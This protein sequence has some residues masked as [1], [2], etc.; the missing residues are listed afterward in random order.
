MN[1]P[2]FRIKRKNEESL[3][4]HITTENFADILTGE[5]IFY[6]QGSCGSGIE[7]DSIG[8][9]VNG[10]TVS[11]LVL[12]LRNIKKILGSNTQ[13]NKRQFDLLASERLQKENIPEHQGWNARVWI[14]LQLT[15]FDVVHW[16]WAK[17]NTNLA[18]WNK[19]DGKYNISYQ[20]RLFSQPVNRGCLSRLWL[21]NKI[22]IDPNPPSDKN[23][24]HLIECLLED[25]KVAIIERTTA[26]SDARLA[27]AIARRYAELPTPTT[28]KAVPNS[29]VLRRVMKL[30][31]LRMAGIET[32]ALDD[33]QLKEFVKKCFLDAQDANN[34]KKDS[35][36]PK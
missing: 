28:L 3:A 10:Q 7:F 14:F 12:D 19:T 26:S 18:A 1:W 6:D 17:E 23:S 11:T 33:H 16:R 35:S 9:P 34:W 32:L 20:D 22:L 21:W 27:M 24:R 2:Q 31:I 4:S 25:N 36:R 5:Q 8:E 30:T 15:L 29:Q 13:E